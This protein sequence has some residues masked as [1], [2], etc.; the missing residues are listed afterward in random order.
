MS[1]SN[2]QD[3]NYKMQRVKEARLARKIIIVIF[4]LLI[5]VIS[6]G[7]YYAYSYIAE[8]LRPVDKEDDTI[9]DI[10]IPLGSSVEAIGNIL[11]ENNIINNSRIFK[12][13]VKFKNESGF[14][15][16]EY[17][18]SK[19]MT[20]DE[21]I[22]SLKTGKILVD[23]LFTITIPEGTTIEQIAGILQSKTS[24][25]EEEFLEKMTDVEY[26]QSLIPL[27]PSILSEEILKDN[28]RYPLEGYL[29]AATYPFYDKNPT[30]EQFVEL[31]LQQSEQRIQPYLLDIEQMGLSVH[32]A[33]T[34][35]SLI[36]E[37]AV[38][39]EDRKMVSGVFYN[40]MNSQPPMPLQTDPT[41]LYAL[42]GHKE[43]VLYEDLEVDSPYN[44]Y[45]YPGLPPGP[46]ANFHENALQAALYPEEHE[47]YYFVASYEG[48]VYYATTLQEH[49]ENIN[50]YRPPQD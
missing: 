7:G 11:E 17:K 32:E 40:R 20:L 3:E 31:L 25:T 21:I 19:S 48:D 26:I 35:A 24:I 8:G 5:I 44:T 13:Y 9:I 6:L 30:V 46:I 27:Y 14:Q 37:E 12:Y 23:P 42:G 22:E 47:Y 10:E 1:N 45:L 16:G 50:K 28:I 15:A 43:R 29:Y 18:L 49:Q 4:A 38:S 36:E 2:D 33:V 41:V 34:M 39:E